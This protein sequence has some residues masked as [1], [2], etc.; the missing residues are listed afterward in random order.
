MYQRHVTGK[1]GEDVVEEYLLNNNYLI[2][3][4]NFRCNFGEIDVVANDVAKDEIVFIEIKTRNN[5]NYGVPAESVTKIKKRHILQTAKYF[6]H[7]YNL[8]KEFIRLDVI[9]VYITNT[10]YNINHIKQ[11]F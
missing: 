4:R 3:Y 11:A 1:Y 6:L 9:E 10:G 2:I 5:N 7:I 8:E